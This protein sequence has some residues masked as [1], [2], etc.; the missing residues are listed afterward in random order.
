MRIRPP[1]FGHFS[2]FDSVN[3]VSPTAALRPFFVGASIQQIIGRVDASFIKR[4][5]LFL[6]NAF[7][8]SDLL[9]HTSPP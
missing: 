3:P 7:D 4:L 8:F 5:A 6:T 2:S 9:G 1:I